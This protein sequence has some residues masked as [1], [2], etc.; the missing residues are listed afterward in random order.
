MNSNKAAEKNKE[1]MN[2]FVNI[3][4]ICED[5]IIRRNRDIPDPK[6]SIEAIKKETENYYTIIKNQK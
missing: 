6:Y 5:Y 1:I 4:N 2:I 3:K